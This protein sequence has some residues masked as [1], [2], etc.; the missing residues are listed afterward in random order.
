MK[1]RFEACAAALQAGELV[2]PLP[3]LELADA[4]QIAARRHALRLATGDRAIGRKIG[5][6]NT[7]S[8]AAQGISAPSWGW[9]YER[10]TAP[11]GDEL[12][13]SAWREPKIELECVLRLG[14]DGRPE[15]MALGLE[16]VDR[17]Y[18]SWAISV[19]D[20]VAAGGVHAAMRIGAWQPLDAALLG[21]LQ[22]ELQVGDARSEGGSPLV[23]GSPLT[24]LARLMALL[25]EQGA[26]P[27]RA[28][29]IITTGALAPAL[30]LRAGE[31]LQARINSLGEL[32]MTLG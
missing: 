16:I 1:S 14:A 25:A 28:G 17:P 2:E 4:Y 26:P 18:P 20:S 30:P 32:R 13:S 24:A 23:F 8:W 10:S 3:G 12:D 29:E 22:A 11:A 5:H 15:A 31:K 9:L 6:T 27:L 7:A 21:D 19:P